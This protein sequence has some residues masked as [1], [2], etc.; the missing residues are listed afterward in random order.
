MWFA[1][2]ENRFDALTEADRLISPTAAARSN[3]DYACKVLKAYFDDLELTL[4]GDEQ[5]ANIAQ[6]QTIWLEISKFILAEKNHILE[7][8]YHRLLNRLTRIYTRGLQQK[9]NQAFAA[10]AT[11]YAALIEIVS[12]A[13]PEFD[14]SEA[15]RHLI[16]YMNQLYK[17]REKSW[18]RIFENLLS[19]PDSIDPIHYLKQHHLK[20]I[21]RWIEEGVENLF[22]I[23]DDQVNL[24]AQ[25]SAELDETVQAIEQLANWLDFNRGSKLVPITRPQKRSSLKSLRKKRE[26]LTAELNSGKELVDLLDR[27]IQEFENK[28]VAT[29]RA[30]YIRLIE[31]STIV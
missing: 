16:H 12:Q 10:T 20:E 21:Q 15:I 8:G 28:M 1:N 17:V 13:Y 14:Y 25:K 3:Q 23:R 11:H 5:S 2:Q 30:S 7:D 9:G 26:R 31:K 18:L 22:Q 6:L 29:R 19:M 24:Y 4:A 27:N